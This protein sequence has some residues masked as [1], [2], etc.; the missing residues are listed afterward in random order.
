MMPPTTIDAKVLKTILHSKNPEE[1]AEWV[2][3]VAPQL[4]T[5][6]DLKFSREHDMALGFLLGCLWL[7]YVHHNVQV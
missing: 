6:Q 1:C 4:S 3:I 7:K 2:F 5:F